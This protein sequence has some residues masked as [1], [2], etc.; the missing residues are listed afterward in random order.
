MNKIDALLELRKVVE[1]KGT[2]RDF[3]NVDDCFC[4]V[5][6]LMN[7]CGTEFS[8]TFIHDRPNSFSIVSIINRELDEAK[9][10]LEAGFTS[11]ELSRLQSVNDHF[12]G[13]ESRK[14]EVIKY[15]DGLLK[16]LSEQ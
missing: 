16:Y 5:G 10:L 3:Y 11:Y 14:T 9:P 6:H 2:I 15:I 8:T 7:I 1:E 4:A 13:D 12:E